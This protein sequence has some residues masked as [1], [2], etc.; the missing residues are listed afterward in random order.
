MRR[1]VIAG[2]AIAGALG[3]GLL[4]APV[5]ADTL[6]GPAAVAPDWAAGRGVAT[7]A[8]DPDSTTTYGGY[9]R[10]GA[11]GRG[12]GSGV[13]PEDRPYADTSVYP[14]GTLT[15]EQKAKLAAIA[16]D[17][18][19]AHDVYVA[20]A[21]STGD[22]RFSRIAD[23]ESQHLSAVRTMLDRYGIDDPTAGLAEG[24]FATEAVQKL[25]DDLLAEGRTSL[26]A[27]LEV[28]QKIEKLDIAD[29]DAAAAGL[30]APDVAAV[31]SNLK[32]GSQRHLAAFG[33]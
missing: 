28:G 11:A 24:E 9:G 12:P 31:Y 10:G 5:I 21:E 30:D 22:T 25:Y 19:L 20:L 29:L 2:A 32:E 18:K 14:S 15:D 26:T 17:E 7:S 16:E 23:S 6:S 33:G 4:A 13:A 8:D 3:L 27:A 1:S